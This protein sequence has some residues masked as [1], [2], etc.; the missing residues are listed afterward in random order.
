MMEKINDS[1]EVAV[2]FS[3]N[4]HCD[5]FECSKMIKFTKI[6]QFVVFQELVSISMCHHHPSMIRYR[7]EFDFDLD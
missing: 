7:E 4:F 1:R 3:S 5:H 2:E 6:D